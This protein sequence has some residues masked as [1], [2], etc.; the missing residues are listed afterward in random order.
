MPSHGGEPD[1][2]SDDGLAPVIPL[3]SASVSTTPRGAGKDARGGP[4]QERWNATWA[5]DYAPGDEDGDGDR[6]RPDESGQIE[7]DIAEKNLLKKLRSRSLSLREARGV[8]AEHDLDD[9]AI[10]TVLSSFERLGY[11]DDAALA[12]QLVHAGS[13]RKG[14]GRKAIAQTLAKRGI[15]RDIADAA[16]ASL[17][18]DD[19]ERALEFARSKAPSMA[20]LDRD[21]AV[22]RLVGQLS[23]RGYSG[24]VAMTAARDAL[25]EATAPRSGVRFR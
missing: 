23:R 21:T 12:E 13:G 19:A 6:G 20:R 7:R 4:Q 9:D 18:D 5:D 17:P 2:G 24:S 22:R 10:E 15:P 8:I 25:D 1:D 16:L 11:L 3:F 14:Q